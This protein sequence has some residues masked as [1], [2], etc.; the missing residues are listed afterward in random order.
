[1]LD[2]NSVVGTEMK[3]LETPVALCARISGVGKASNYPM[4]DDVR[5]AKRRRGPVWRPMAT[6]VSEGNAT[7]QTME[8]RITNGA[9]NLQ[10]VY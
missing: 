10:Q 7:L 2:D 8:C 4:T 6:A 3:H 1:M 5:S 9:T